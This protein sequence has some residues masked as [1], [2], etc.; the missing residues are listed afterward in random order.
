MNSNRIPEN[1]T[2]PTSMTNPVTT[3][4]TTVERIDEYSNYIG[5]NSIA[6]G[7]F[8]IGNN[9]YKDARQMP[10]VCFAAGTYDFTGAHKVRAG[11]QDIGR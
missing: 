6:E 11:L 9:Y 4:L 10:K 3:Q 8:T 5:N 2:N 7:K 1:L